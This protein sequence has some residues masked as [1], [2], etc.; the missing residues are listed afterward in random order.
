MELAL[1]PLNEQQ[2]LADLLALNVLD[3]PNEKVYDDLAELASLVTGCPIA[4]VSFVDQERLWFKA[5]KNFALQEVP[6][7]YSFCSYTIE[8]DD[9]LV[10]EDTLN[11]VRFAE[12]NYTNESRE[13]R[14]YA[15]APLL[16]NNGSR[17]GT[18]C[19]MDYE[20]RQLS[21]Q[22]QKSLQLIASQV[23]NLLQ[24]KS[25]DAQKTEWVTNKLQIE[26]ATLQY[27]IQQQEEE[28]E[29]ISN[30]LRTNFASVIQKC[31]DTLRRP[32]SISVVEAIQRLEMLQK[33]MEQL[34][35][36]LIPFKISSEAIPCFQKLVADFK[37]SSSF[38]AQ[39]LIT[40]DEDTT[41]PRQ[42]LA[43]YRILSELLCAYEQSRAYEM[44][45]TVQLNFGAIAELILIAEGDRSLL[46][47]DEWQIVMNE[48]AYRAQIA[49]GNFESDRDSLNNRILRVSLPLA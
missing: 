33:D 9:V 45:I 46:D 48:T 43:L 15:A 3:T 25:I 28:R 11:D 49:G 2:R 36:N 39:F 17:L 8:T 10:I 42:I 41:Q 19:V 18:V 31:T 7:E 40:G 4:M 20:P 37:E 38:N 1:L 27:R 22:Q 12:I 6:R 21:T 26:K 32:N 44:S 13:I 14:F 30:D 24:Q 47:S 34:A 23:T 5:R 16:L 29:L 35:S